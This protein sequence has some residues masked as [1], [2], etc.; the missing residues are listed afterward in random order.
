MLLQ[1]DLP[2]ERDRRLCR[3]VTYACASI[4]EYMCILVHVLRQ[5]AGETLRREREMGRECVRDKKFKC[6]MTLCLECRH[7][8]AHTH[9]GGH[10][11]PPRPPPT[12]VHTDAS[13]EII[14]T[15]IHAETLIPNPKPKIL[16]LTKHC[17]CFT[18]NDP[19]GDPDPKPSN[20]NLHTK[21]SPKTIITGASLQRT[22]TEIASS[23]GKSWIMKPPPY[24][25]ITRPCAMA[26]GE[27]PVAG[28]A[29]NTQ[30]HTCGGT[31]VELDD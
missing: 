16:M 8:R 27:V 9:T 7:T 31:G 25:S 19:H 21:L 20:F 2:S 11:H 6:P 30:T 5:P 17:I 12:H 10:T 24:Q 15:D 22:R 1:G 3:A 26:Y 4:Y 13:R 18:A 14:H 29:T 28:K 23:T